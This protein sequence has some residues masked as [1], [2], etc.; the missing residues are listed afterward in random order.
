M[1]NKGRKRLPFLRN[2]PGSSL[3]KTEATEAEQ[4]F[5]LIP[6]DGGKGHISAYHGL[7]VYNNI[8]LNVTHLKQHGIF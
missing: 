4:E 8:H 3:W 6:S 2:F 1:R 7:P 5:N